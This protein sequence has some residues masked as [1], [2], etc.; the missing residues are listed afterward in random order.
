MNFLVDVLIILVAAK[1]A[2]EVAERI[3]LPPVVGEIL[4]GMVIGPSVLN[5]VR[6][7]EVLHVLGELGVILLL[8]DVGLQMELKDL[9]AV[10][11]SAFT[12]A[13]LGVTVPFVLGWGA[14]SALGLDTRTA[15]FLGAALTATSV[16]ITARVFAD[17]RFLASVEARTVLGAAVVDDVMGLIILTVV[18]RI[19]SGGTVSLA[20]IGGVIALAVAFLVLTTAIGVRFAPPMFRAISRFSRSP[21]TLVALTLA[22]TLA[23]SGLA[24]LAKLA[25]IV[26]AF[27]AGLAL[28]RADQSDR[29][30]AEI[31]PIGHIFVPVF[32]LQIG[33]DADVA[34]FANL[35]VLGLAAVLL[36]AAVIG[37]LVASVGVV[38]SSGDR[39]LIGLGMLPRGEVGLIFAGIG[40]RSGVLGQN[41]YGALLVVVLATT[42][43]APPL[44]RWR[45]NTLRARDE[46]EP[47]FTPMP[48]AGW[49]SI[50]DGRIEL[51]GHPADHLTL[52]VALEASLLA[53][54]HPPGDSLL[55]WLT[56]AEDVALRWEK[57]ETDQLFRL[58]TDGNAR[59]WRLLEAAGI[60]ERALP[61]LAEA[62]RRRRRDPFQLDPMG[63][64]CW[65]LVDRVHDLAEGD[66]LAAEEYQRLAHPERLALAALILDTQS[67]PGQP[68]VA[69]RSLVKRLDLGAA[70][71]QE[72]ALL[73]ADSSL[74]RSAAVRH[75]V[76]GESVV[77]PIALHVEQAER[78][79]ALYL[80]S[81]A[82]GPIDSDER[83][84]LDELSSQVQEALS[85]PELTS[86]PARNLVERRRSEAV[87]IV[88]AETPAAARVND[89]PL[90]Y[91]L[92]QSSSA[93]ARQ[94]EFLDPVAPRRRPRVE[95]AAD[96]VGGGSDHWRIEIAARDQPGLLAAATDV[97]SSAALHVVEAIIATWPDG[98]ALESFLVR[99]SVP[100]D[101][102]RLAVALGRALDTPSPWSPVP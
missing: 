27:V 1:V 44:L 41:A 85:H 38:G 91:L 12:V 26:G 2:A 43:M 10:G 74:M 65:N 21:G 24:T 86:R 99:S 83:Q 33:I 94:C 4:A 63:L 66:P 79:R 69:A 45:R 52:H 13:V 46:P 76:I 48:A 14:A 92:A 40:L 96:D 59:S 5:L 11:R 57:K 71:E 8:L 73:V 3:G 34:Q 82:L 93:V 7:G 20:T 77:I 89:A 97:L 37:K 51:S 29:I 81:L 70:A 56:A 17:L 90:G 95:V 68:V 72:V 28:A 50:V 53:A 31:T 80:L 100:P 78:A 55:L 49:L 88:G 32:F 47:D 9:R 60:L 25:P 30:R 75:L 15:I 35:S 19:V 23:F 36:V 42:L 22:F 67:E 54:E 87:R 58:L 6:G 64:L 39:P 61:E 16:G 84:R 102:D 62:Y 101:P 18:V 98:A